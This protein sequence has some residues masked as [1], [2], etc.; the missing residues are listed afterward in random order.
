MAERREDHHEADEA[1]ARRDLET[2]GRRWS[3][4]P[5]V[6]YVLLLVVLV[7]ILAIAL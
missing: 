7:F 6:Y 4:N 2:L 5:N 3:S 1:R